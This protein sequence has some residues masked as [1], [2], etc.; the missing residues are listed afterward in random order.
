[1]TLTRYCDGDMPTKQYADVLQKIHEDPVYYLSIL[2]ANKGNLISQTAYEKSKRTTLELASC[3]TIPSVNYE[4]K[5][6]VVHH[7][8]ECRQEQYVL[9]M[10]EAAADKNYMKRTIDTQDAFCNADGEADGE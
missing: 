4:I 6:A 9:Q 2:E 10:T 5:D 8:A 1:M 7:I 3:K